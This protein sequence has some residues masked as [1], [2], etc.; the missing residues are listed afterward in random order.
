MN[1]LSTLLEKNVLSSSPSNDTGGLIK[2]SAGNYK[3]IDTTKSRRMC[4]THG[5]FRL[6]NIVFDTEV[7][8]KILAV[9]DWELSCVGDPMMDL[10]YFCMGH[11]LPPIGFLKKV[12]LLGR[13]DIN[14]NNSTNDNNN[15][16]NNNNN[17]NDSMNFPPGIPLEK[18]IAHIYSTHSAALT[19]REQPI[20]NTEDNTWKFFLALGL[21][22]A[23]SIAS[24]VYARSR[25]GNASSIRAVM[26]RDL[27]Y[28]LSKKALEIVQTSSDSTSRSSSSLKAPLGDIVK[29]TTESSDV[30]SIMPREPSE[31]CKILLKKLKH[32]NDTVAIPCEEQLIEHYMQAEGKWPNRYFIY[33]TICHFVITSA[34]LFAIL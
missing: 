15:N 11:H 21:F 3:V 4:L 13:G 6:D 1:I 20:I 8:S 31:Q 30:P 25:Q 5:D 29:P 16:N 2:I 14:N 24:G 27:V 10:T 23:A 34:M 28:I 33:Y 17:S 9:L 32:F 7:P 18:D 12:S 26:Y 22:R 19:L